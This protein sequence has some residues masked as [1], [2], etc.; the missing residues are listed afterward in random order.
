MSIQDLVVPFGVFSVVVSG[1]V[2]LL[3]MQH[4][5][6][7]DQKFDELMKSRESQNEKITALE[8]KVT[9]VEERQNNVV[10]HTDLTEINKHLSKVSSD[11]EHQTREL[12]KVSRQV[13]FISNFLLENK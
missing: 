5:K 4:Q 10:R 13:E 12:A 1:L 11:N 8:S 3:L 2:K 6:H 9:R 7:V